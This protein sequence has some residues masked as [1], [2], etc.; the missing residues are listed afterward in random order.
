MKRGRKIKH[1]EKILKCIEQEVNTVPEMRKILNIPGQFI[2]QAIYQMIKKNILYIKEE[3]QR[4]SAGNYEIVYGIVKPGQI[5]PDI[6]V[7]ADDVEYAKKWKN[8]TGNPRLM[9]QG[10]EG[11]FRRYCA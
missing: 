5:I 2:Y 9:W 8:E 3:K 4:G 1:S 10:T 7:P 6:E 11:N